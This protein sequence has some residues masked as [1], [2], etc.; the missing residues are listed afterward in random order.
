MKMVP[1][2]RH[3]LIHYFTNPAEVN[4]RVLG[5]GNINDT[6]LASSPEQTLVL[7]RIN[8]LVFPQPER[9]IHNL[10]IVSEY[11]QS[12]TGQ[13]KQRWQDT[14]L[15]PTLA[16]EGSVKDE[17]NNLWR[18]L[19]YIDKSISIA[20]VQNTLQ[21]NQTGWA[22]GRFHKKLAGLN[23]QLLEIPLPGFHLLSSY[24]DKY[25]ALNHRSSSSK[26][27]QRCRESIAS[28]RMAALSLE[29]AANN[30]S[31]STAIIHGDPKIGN[32]L[33][34]KKTG[35]AL[36]IIDLDTIGP[37]FFQHDIG[38]CLR[39]V[40]NRGGESNP[41]STTEFDM[42]FCQATLKGYLGEAANL[43]T[44]V[45]LE[46][47]YDGIRA[48]TFEL[49]LRFFTDYLQGNVYF[50]CSTPETNLQKALTQFTL[51]QDISEKEFHIR[52]LISEYS[53]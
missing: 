50:K 34:D 17:E 18:A 46:Y 15:I 7:Q 39:S 6:F 43:L 24:L 42:V 14:V 28:N 13:E 20:E 5:E 9:L 11:L 53:N 48:I 33:F 31:I 16:G 30:G 47:I 25:D 49:G 3:I 27:I 37:G 4:I 40:C 29:R 12:Y 52:S 36:S 38:D 2:M 26:N 44:A 45:D 35:K 8:S 51:L 22:L 1:P 10:Q 19:S 32:I 23:V 41:A 21:A